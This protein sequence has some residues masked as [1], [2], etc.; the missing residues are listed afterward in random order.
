MLNTSLKP[1]AR[2]LVSEIWKSQKENGE[3]KTRNETA[4]KTILST[5]AFCFK[6]TFVSL[7]GFNKDHSDKINSF[8]R[9]A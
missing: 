6:A 4:P 9:S 2:G 8:S 7:G 1:Q 5:W 3:T